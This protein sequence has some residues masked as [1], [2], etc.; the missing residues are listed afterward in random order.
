MNLVKCNL[1]DESVQIFV[2]CYFPEIQTLNFE[3]NDFSD[4]LL[5]IIVQQK[6]NKLKKMD[7][8]FNS[9]FDGIFGN[10]ISKF[11][12]LYPFKTEEKNKVKS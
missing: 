1:N 10:R 9:E 3:Y 12:F 11:T 4:K 2:K 5:Q 7:I 8:N 6:W